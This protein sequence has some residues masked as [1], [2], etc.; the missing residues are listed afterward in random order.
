M[1]RSRYKRH[2]RPH[3]NSFRNMTYICRPLPV[4]RLLNGSSSTPPRGG[5]FDLKLG[6]D[7]TA[8][9]RNN[10][11]AHGLTLFTLRNGSAKECRM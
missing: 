8:F 11:A 9:G 2:S 7:V 1:K 10:F 6:W 3:G 5:G 4:S